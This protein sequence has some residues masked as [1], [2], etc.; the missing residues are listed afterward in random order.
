MWSAAGGDGGVGHELTEHHTL[1]AL[2]T[3]G[4]KAG[5]IEGVDD[6][7]RAEGGVHDRAAFLLQA[8]GDEPGRN[9][10]QKASAGDGG[11]VVN[12]LSEAVDGGGGVG[13]QDAPYRGGCVL[14]G[15]VLGLDADEGGLG[16]TVAGDGFGYF[17]ALEFQVEVLL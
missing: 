14:D 4:G 6:D 13:F 10:Q 16:S 5:G 1:R 12:H 3:G 11:K 9:H 8:A 2:R 7:F 17:L 15:A